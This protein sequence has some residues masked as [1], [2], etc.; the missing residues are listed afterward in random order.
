M[1]HVIHTKTM[2][3]FKL[4]RYSDCMFSSLDP[5]ELI[6]FSTWSFGWN[7]FILMVRTN[8][9]NC[10]SYWHQQRLSYKHLRLW[11][12]H[13]LVRV[14]PSR[15]HGCPT[16]HTLRHLL[17]S[18]S[19]IFISTNVPDPSFFWLS[20]TETSDVKLMRIRPDR[21]RSLAS[22]S[23]VWSLS[24]NTTI[25]DPSVIKRFVRFTFDT[26]ELSSP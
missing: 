2:I 13:L 8:K 18:S 1:P 17:S 14:L 20:F 9:F 21:S 24:D 22:V 11:L 4:S 12:P 7:R 26:I 25:L 10:S 6:L 23:V 19:I 16:V 15:P 5:L 3:T